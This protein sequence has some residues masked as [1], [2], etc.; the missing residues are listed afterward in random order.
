[1]VALPGPGSPPGVPMIGV[2]P[3]Q[4]HPLISFIQVSPSPVGALSLT[5][6]LT[7]HTQGPVHPATWRGQ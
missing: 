2:S 5:G 3:A 4:R 1:M 7:T 6:L